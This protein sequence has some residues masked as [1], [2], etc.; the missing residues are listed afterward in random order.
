MVNAPLTPTPT[1]RRTDDIDFMILQM[2][3]DRRVKREDAK[4]SIF[5]NSNIEAIA[6]PFLVEETYQIPGIWCATDENAKPSSPK[7]TKFG[8]S[9]Q[10]RNLNPIF[11]SC[12]ER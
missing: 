2:D 10:P 4:R 1:Q 11:L 8:Y 9:L 7:R 6:A 5:S 3:R 12:E